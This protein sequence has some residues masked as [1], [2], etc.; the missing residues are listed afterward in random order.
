[1]NTL[2]LSLAQRPLQT[3]SP[4]LQQAVRL[5]QLSTAEFLQTVDEALQYNPFLEGETSGPDTDPVACAVEIP[6]CASPAER[7]ADGGWADLATRPLRQGSTAVSA[8]DFT[9]TTIS[10]QDHLLEQLR[11]QRLADR[12]LVLCGVVIESLEEDG[13]LRSPLADVGMFAQL[14]PA[15][16]AEELRCA[17]LRVQALEPLGVGARDL[18]ECLALQ[19]PLLPDAQ[20]RDLCSRMVAQHAGRLARLDFRHVATALHC[21]V[22]RARA[23]F[24]QLRRLDPH[25]GWRYGATPTRYVTP[26]VFVRRSSDGWKAT[27]NEAV[28][29]RVWINQNY[30]Q[31]LEREGRAAHG[32]LSAQLSEARFTLRNVQ[33]RFSTILSVA[34]AILRRQQ[35]FFEHGAIALQPLALREIAE[36]IGAHTSTVSRVTHGKYMQTPSGTYELKFFFSRG[37]QGEGDRTCAPQAVRTL[38]GEIIAAEPPH[39]A[40]SDVAIAQLLSRQ[41]VHLA[42]RTVTKYRQLLGIAPCEQRQ[43]AGAQHPVRHGA[44]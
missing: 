3:L 34:Q 40:L 9:A 2:A 19:L 7:P 32:A 15:A 25:P 41:G 43:R 38:V 14:Q 23:A 21:T 4:R 39:A 29:P 11:L 17:L 10:L 27:L 28:V 36:E 22:E 8:L 42:R 37:L 31:M 16:S 18:A 26:D 44:A 1:M 30:A 20:D 12:D 5:L 24:D 6:A 35:R 33:Q 13:Y